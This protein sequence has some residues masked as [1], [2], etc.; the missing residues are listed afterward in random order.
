MLFN[1]T[2]IGWLLGRG[3]IVRAMVL[4]AMTSI[5]SILF[6]L[7]AVVYFDLGVRGV[8]SASMAAELTTALVGA[9][10]LVLAVGR[11]RDRGLAAR[12][13]DTA[14]VRRVVTVNS[15]LLVRSMTVF[16]VMAWFTRESAALGTATLAVNAVLINVFYISATLMDGSAVAAQQLAGSAVGAHS[17]KRF[18]EAAGLTLLLGAVLATCIALA[19]IL[20]QPWLIPTLVA[21]DTVRE[22]ARHYFLWP[23]VAQFFGAIAFVCDGLFIGATWTREARN[24]MLLAAGVFLA[25]WAVLVPVFGSHG[26]WAALVIFLA[27]RSV[28]YLW[29]LRRLVPQTFGAT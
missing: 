3:M 13:A 7:T 6:C 27:S 24:L 10:L 19:L 26:L 9:V 14:K 23:V 28:A 15:H 2:M 8:A 1:L 29:S 5:L 25:A 22:G 12:V 21:I 4:Q 17:L 16:F 11:S 20:L 18:R